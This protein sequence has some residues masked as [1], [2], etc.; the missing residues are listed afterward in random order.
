[1]KKHMQY[2]SAHLGCQLS[3]AMI[4]MMSAAHEERLHI[5]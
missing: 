5:C 3:E 2:Q 4:P 1:M